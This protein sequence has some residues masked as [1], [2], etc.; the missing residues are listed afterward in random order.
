M[1]VSGDVRV[2]SVA[3][4]YCVFSFFSFFSFLFFSSSFFLLSL[5]C[6]MP[7][8]T[9]SQPSEFSLTHPLFNSIQLPGDA[10]TIVCRLIKKER[11]EEKKEEKKVWN[12]LSW[13]SSAEQGQAKKQI[14]T[15]IDE[16][17]ESMLQTI[18]TCCPS[19]SG[20]LPAMLT[21]H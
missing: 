9:L 14:T 2:V 7:L 20:L 10:P 4:S 17:L 8:H 11:K 16:P 19:V 3:V 1:I 12:K 13:W 6:S 21:G 5:L 15:D 18:W